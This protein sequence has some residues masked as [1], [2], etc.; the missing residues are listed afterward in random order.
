MDLHRIGF[1]PVLWEED[2]PDWNNGDKKY[3]E[4]VEIEMERMK[5]TMR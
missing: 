5:K 1:H 3:Y 4:E 2:E